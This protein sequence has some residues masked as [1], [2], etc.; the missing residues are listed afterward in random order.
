M[1][2]GD[3]KLLLQVAVYICTLVFHNVV[4]LQHSLL[5]ISRHHALVPC[6]EALRQSTLRKVSQ[7]TYAHAT[8][9]EMN[10]QRTVWTEG[11]PAMH[12]DACFD[13]DPIT[14]ATGLKV[15]PL[16]KLCIA[17]ADAGTGICTACV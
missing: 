13:F 9:Y 10:K 15:C 5:A 4:T 8:G 12:P 17:G 11:K 3:I 16:C 1:A 14:V 6:A 2:T 7:W